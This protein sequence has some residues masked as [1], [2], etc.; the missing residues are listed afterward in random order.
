M[1]KME[2]GEE[3]KMEETRWKCSNMQG[4]AAK[5]PNGGRHACKVGRLVGRTERSAVPNVQ[6][7]CVCINLMPSRH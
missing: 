2:N 7:Q 4:N 5:V 3:E 1:G 6:S